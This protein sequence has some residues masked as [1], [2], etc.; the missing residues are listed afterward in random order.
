VPARD[1]AGAGDDALFARD[2]FAATHVTVLP[3]QYLG[4]DAHGVN[5]GRGYVRIALVP[6]LADCVD[7][8]RRI[9]AFCH[10]WP[11]AASH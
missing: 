4:R 8:A 1:G 11:T 10:A 2:L 7:A 9:V 6:E 5:P 3:G